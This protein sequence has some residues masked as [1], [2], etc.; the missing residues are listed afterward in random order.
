M[1][2]Q[3]AHKLFKGMLPYSSCGEDEVRESRV[4][5][6]EQRRVKLGGMGKIFGILQLNVEFVPSIHGLSAVCYWACLVIV[7]IFALK[8]Y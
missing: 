7:N 6:V 5:E 2:H 3:R 8:K 4:G 1:H